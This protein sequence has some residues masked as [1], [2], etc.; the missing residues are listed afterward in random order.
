MDIFY[1]NLGGTFYLLISVLDG[2]S[3]RI[4]HGDICERMEEQDVE[5]VLQ[6]ALEKTPGAKP[7][8]ISDNGP[9]FIAIGA[10]ETLFELKTNIQISTS[11]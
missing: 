9:Q 4:V 6:K 2:F 11:G 3:R 5:M 8:V 7:R 10:P 1:L